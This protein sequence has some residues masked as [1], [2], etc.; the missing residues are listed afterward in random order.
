MRTKQGSCHTPPRLPRERGGEAGFSLVEGL[1]AAALL[2]VISISVLPLFTRALE[3]NISGGRSSQLSTFV[4]ADI[5]AVNQLPVDGDAWDLPM[6]GVLD[7]GTQK[8]DVGALFDA[9]AVHY[10]GDE[11]W[12]DDGDSHDGPLMWSRN[13]EVRKYSLADIQI[14]IGT[15]GG[16]V[17]GGAAGAS[18]FLFDNPL[19]TDENAHLAEIRVTVKE[20]RNALP[21]ASGKR[22]TVGHFR[23]F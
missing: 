14:L 18:P 21:A 16:L 9:D 10:L 4:S 11:K 22:I 2:L 23:S 1:I 3:S 12:V 7:L 20:Q 6:S 17:T 5:E 13:A 19:T 15:S 8:W